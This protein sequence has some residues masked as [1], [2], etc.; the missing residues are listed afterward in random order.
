MTVDIRSSQFW[1]D[2]WHNHIQGDTAAMSK[3]Y[4][5]PEFWDGRAEEYYQG[6]EE[7][8]RIEAEE[9]TDRIERYGYLSNGAEVLDIGCGTG[10]LA[11]A[12]ARRGAKVTALDFSSGMLKRLIDDMPQELKNNITVLQSGWDEIDLEKRGWENTFDLVVSNMSPAIHDPATLQKMVSASSKACYLKAWVTRKR[13]SAV[14]EDIWKLLAGKP[15]ED[16]HAPFP[17]MLN[18]VMA[19]GYFPDVLYKKIEFTTNM[20]LDKAL[21]EHIHYFSTVFGDTSHD[22]EGKII[23]YLKQAAQDGMIDETITGRT[24][25]LLWPVG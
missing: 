6:H 18:L 5:T 7:E 16:R 11:F 1:I 21:T 19:M 3:G 24:G 9:T 17:Y 25:S 12:L 8:G 23:A 10:T 4:S 13:H 14:Q 2:Q 20:T 22:L 15:L